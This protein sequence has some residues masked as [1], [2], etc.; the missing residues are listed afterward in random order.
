MFS[1]RTFSVEARKNTSEALEAATPEKPVAPPKYTEEEL[2]MV[3]TMLK[4]NEV[5]IDEKMKVQTKL[6]EDATNDPVILTKDLNERGKKL[7]M[8]VGQRDQPKD[9]ADLQ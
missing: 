9:S 7:Q 2:S 3:E 4:D 6:N 5:W 1:A 8:T